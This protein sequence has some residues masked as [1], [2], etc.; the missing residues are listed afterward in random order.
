MVSCIK[1]ELFSFSDVS[2][3]THTHTHA[4]MH[5]HIQSNTHTQT[6][7]CPTLG[8]S[9][10]IANQD[11]AHYI[12]IDLYMNGLPPLCW[13]CFSCGDYSA[14]CVRSECHDNWLSH[15]KAFVD[16]SNTPFIAIKYI[17]KVSLKLFKDCVT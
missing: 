7:I 16:L 1:C 8:V 15:S 10:K 2:V 17:L 11:E 13:Y 5:V 3:Y 6:V 14:P 9:G 4:L 12:L